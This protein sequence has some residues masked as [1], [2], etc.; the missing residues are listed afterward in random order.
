MMNLQV[1]KSS[2]QKKTFTHR[3]LAHIPLINTTRAALIDIC[4]T[5]K[6]NH[7]ILA[8]EEEEANYETV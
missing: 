6:R 2:G 8:T 7:M 3:S 4:K 1:L 5:R